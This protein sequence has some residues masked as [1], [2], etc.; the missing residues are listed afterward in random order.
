MQK[1]VIWI[2]LLLTG[3]QIFGQSKET[4]NIRAYREKQ[5]HQWLEEFTSFLS[6]P[7]IAGDTVNMQKNAAFIQ[8]MMLKRGISNIQ[9]LYPKTP[10]IPPAVYGEALVA[11]ATKTIIFYAHYDGQPVD[12]TKW[13]K[14]L[15]PFKPTLLNGSLEQHATIINWPGSA[16]PINPE[17]RIYSRSASDDKAGVMSILSAYESM[18]ACG[19]LRNFNIKFFFEGEEEAG[20]DHLHEILEKYAP[21]LQSNLWVICDGP[22]H[23]SGKKMVAFGVRGDA[24]AEL[25]VYGSKRP[26]HSGHYGNWAPNPAWMLSRLLASMKND[27]G[28]VLIKG[29]YDDVIPLSEKEKKAVME[30]PSPDAQMKN[31]LGFIEQENT[32]KTLAE[33]LLMPSLNIN[34]MQSANVGKL[35][36]NIIPTTA[37]A[38]LD[39]RLVPG[40]DFKKQQEKL[41]K[42]VKEQGY[43]VTDKEPTD[44]ERK[45]YPKIAKLVL[46]D[47]YNAQRTSMDLPIAQNLIAAVKS[48]TSEQVVLMPSMGG[49]LP[50]FVF[51]KYLNAKTI[52][53]PIANHDNNQHAE[54]ENIR[55]QNLWNGMETFAAIMMMK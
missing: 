34:G 20:S 52:S 31:E 29:F 2:F 51:E 30:I 27:H 54:N 16:E 18:I 48:T 7:N 26:L 22:V 39:L 38:S 3:S 40:N 12:S 41:V 49:S 11:G 15:H 25:T 55:L 21:Q 45:R 28:K 35:S 44:A 13:W 6:I 14:G 19:Y 9:L 24:H 50:L 43:F 1:L 42:H 23:Q 32:D 47:G 37:T 33:S 4:F 36:S 17:W 10:G 46:S 5:S 53:V 8:Q